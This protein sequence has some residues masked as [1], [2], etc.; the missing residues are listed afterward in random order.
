M[1]PTPRKVVLDLGLPEPYRK[2]K[3]TSSSREINLSEST[4]NFLGPYNIYPP[5]QPEDIRQLYLDRTTETDCAKGVRQEQCDFL[6]IDH[7]FLTQGAVEGFELILK[8]FGDRGD[9][10]S[11]FRPSFMAYEH[12]AKLFELDLVPIEY[13]RDDLK[14]FSIDKIIN[15][16]PR[17]LVICDPNNPTG[18]RYDQG[19]LEQ[20]LKE[21]PDSVIVVDEVYIEFA[22]GQ[23]ALVLLKNYH[24]LIILRTLSKAWGAAGIRIGVVLAHPTIIDLMKL[25]QVPFALSKLSYDVALEILTNPDV[26]IESIFNIRRERQKLIDGLKSLPDVVD[27]YQSESNFIL[28]VFKDAEKIIS[29][30]KDSEILVANIGYMVPNGLKISVGNQEQNNM[31]LRCLYSY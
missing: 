22:E 1:V 25:V 16:R 28:A 3:R 7:V 14:S 18:L 13:D 30:L 21:M 19:T 20:L 6:T 17:I 8:I 24:N 9:R 15:L 11:Y 12:W 29:K 31:I 5:L 4:N 26:V 10:I 27:V 2:K 23:S